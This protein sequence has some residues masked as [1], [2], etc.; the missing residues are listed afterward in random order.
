MS[1]FSFSEN[2]TK[3]IAF[4]GISSIMLVI[5]WWSSEYK[6][7][8]EIEVELSQNLRK[9]KDLERKLMML[10]AT[11]L[12]NNNNED[13]SKG[14]R[15]FMDGAFD[16]MHY[17]HANAFRLGR[18]LGTCLVV[19]VNDSQSI[20]DSKGSN[21]VMND[22]ERV[23]VVKSCRWVDEVITHVP[24]VMNDEYLD[25][26]FTEHKIDYI[27]HGDDPCIVN[28]RNVYEAAIKRGKYLEIPR[29]EGIS[30][31]DVV[32]RMLLLNKSHHTHEQNQ[33]ISVTTTTTS[34]SQ[35][36]LQQKENDQYAEI[37]KIDDANDN[38]NENDNKTDN[39]DDSPSQSLGRL[40]NF[41]T[42]SSMMKLFSAGV[43]SPLPDATILY[44]PGCWDMFNAGHVNLLKR[45]R[46]LASCAYVI[47]GVYNDDLV[48]R[49]RGTNLPI[50]NMHERVLSV[51][52]CRYV[53]DV[54]I[55]APYIITNELINSLG[56]KCVIRCNELLQDVSLLNVSN[57]NCGNSNSSSSSNNN[58]NNS[59]IES[60]S[61][62][63]DL[64]ILTEVSYDRRHPIL[65]PVHILDRLYP[66]IKFIQ[67]R[68]L[69]KKQI[70]KKFLSNK[71]NSSSDSD[72]H[73][74]SN[75]NR[76]GNGGKN[77]V[78]FISARHVMTSLK[79]TVVNSASSSSVST[80]T[81]DNNRM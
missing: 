28:G 70:E 16:L 29:T 74:V 77:Q 64:G 78:P 17:G 20:T 26:L 18:S 35:S 14:I 30:T 41:L 49:M 50:M 22:E 1:Y 71:Y 46:S 79:K 23:A 43:K 39:D 7:K 66:N 6:E 75:S 52:G 24:Y 19:G 51:L 4:L 54:L 25:Y 15:V 40:S 10:E 32:G 80:S 65:Q 2:K 76:N 9:V 13:G 42:T 68:N 47:V 55:D 5:Q 31:T 12:S 57:S 60:F 21:P 73:G 8:K 36:D 67:D 44:V 3:T 72:L 56:V 37:I 38:K 11:D 61:I 34:S 33:N 58:N 53:D 48:N 62:P 27:V 63:K 69:R 81:V 45:I 59:L